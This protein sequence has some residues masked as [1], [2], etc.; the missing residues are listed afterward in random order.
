MNGL[1]I[2]EVRQAPT[3]AGGFIFNTPEFQSLKTGILKYF[4]L[5]KNDQLYARLCF[6]LDKNQ[7]VS[8]HQSTFG[9][10]DSV[11]PVSEE[12]AKYFL[13]EAGRMLKADGIKEVI[14]KH[15]PDCYADS[16]SMQKIFSELG[17]E[18]MSNEINQHLI[19]Q[20]Q[21]FKLLIR[22]NERK[23]LNQC[24]NQGYSFKI[25]SIDDLAA[26]Y[27][28]VTQTRVRKGYPVSMDYELLYQTIQSLPDKYLLFGLFAKDELIAA[29][30]SIRIS[31]NILYNFYH[32]DEVSYRS[33]SPLVMLVRE[34]YNYCQHNGIKILDLG[35]SSE[36]GQKNE[37]LFVFKENLGCISAGKKTY[38]LSYE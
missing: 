37:G 7:A 22:K 1:K 21:E 25:L 33:T 23:K 24:I 16:D 12:E 18:L 26:V 30:V 20:D 6:S 34:I 29:S 10:I 28:L 32:A 14:I 31:E 2:R 3:I 27:Q 8:G 11:Y 4:V 36:K 19:V 17:Y 35:V 9:S 15:W 5:F 38:I 13:E